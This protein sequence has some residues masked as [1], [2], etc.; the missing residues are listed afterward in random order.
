MDTG[1]LSLRRS[2]LATLA[3]FDLSDYPLTLTELKR[4]RYRFPEDRADEKRPLADMLAALEAVGARTREGYWFLPGRE[5]I[6]ATRQRRYRLA[7]AKFRKARVVARFLRLLPPVRMV[8]VCNS[9]AV[10]NAD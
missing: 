1:S 9:L 10:S 7:E 6:V 8:A 5:A 3:Y 4:Y 2:L